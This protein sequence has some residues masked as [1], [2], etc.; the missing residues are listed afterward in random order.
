MRLHTAHNHGTCPKCNIDGCERNVEGYTVSKD[1]FRKI[2]YVCPNCL[3]T[4]YENYKFEFVGNFN[5]HTNEPVAPVIAKNKKDVLNNAHIDGTGSRC[6]DA[7][8]CNGWETDYTEDDKHFK[9][10]HYVCHNCLF[11][12]FGLYEI[13]FVGWFDDASLVPIVTPNP[14]KRVIRTD[15]QFR[16]DLE[17]K[18][19]KQA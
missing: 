5:E 13:K 17:I 16:K 15:A 2:R 3:Y 8:E 4:W 7:A 9:Q 12:W 14:K 19:R 11:T 18:N 1:E 6:T 10:I